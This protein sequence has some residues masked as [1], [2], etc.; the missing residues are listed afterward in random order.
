M[1]TAAVAV[2]VAAPWHV[3]SWVLLGS[4]VPDTFVF[5]TVEH[6][7]EGATLANPLTYLETYP[8]APL[9]VVIVPMVAGALCLAGWAAAVAAGRRHPAGAAVAA[10]GFAG[11]AHYGVLGALG[12]PP[13]LWYYGPLMA[14]LTLCAAITAAMLVRRPASWGAGGAATVVVGAALVVLL[15]EQLPWR[16]PP[17]LGNYATAAEFATVGLEVAEIVPDGAAVRSPG[18]IGALTY[19]CE[20]RML[21]KFSHRGI[22][23]EQ[24]DQKLASAGPVTQQLLEWNYA[25]L[26]DDLET[27]PTLEWR[28]GFRP[29]PSTRAP[30]DVQWWPATMSWHKPAQVVLVRK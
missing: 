28:L 2:V 23:A 7:W 26:P 1:A 9:L 14:G 8:L 27:P 6:D 11:L 13:Y 21:D 10:S 20:C 12:V 17:L 5:K 25:F 29:D 3:A 18:E 19:F 30:A 16:E 22:A 4:V 15:S 24:I